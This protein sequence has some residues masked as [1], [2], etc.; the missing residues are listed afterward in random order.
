M[1]LVVTHR[2]E[3]R[4]DRPLSYALQRLRLT[5]RGG[6]VQSV[7]SWSVEIE[8]GRKEV[9]FSDHLGNLTDLVS[10]AGEPHVLGITASGV[11]VTKDAAGVS[12][13]HRGFAPLWLYKR[14]TALTQPGEG[15][16]RLA[17]DMPE[18]AELDRL[19]ELMRIVAER[20]EYM[21]GATASDTDAEAALSK[22]QGVCQDHAHIFLAA[23]RLLGFPARYVSGYLLM[24]GAA[25]QTA[26]HAWAEAHVDALGWVAFDTANGISPDERYVRLAVGR[27]YREASP[28]SGIRHGSA[29]EELSVH[30]RV[31]QQ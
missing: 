1:R 19:H 29:K 28:V 14:Q 23:A 21:P 18:M 2:T 10:V 30:I 15:I 20:V 3:Y 7:E 24:E 8:G 6:A 26:S 27:D 13:P 17:A 16:A 25:E 4:Y 12:G 31:E 11:V 22:G 5:P 9:S